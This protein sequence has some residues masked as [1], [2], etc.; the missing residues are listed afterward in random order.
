LREP[1][2]VA[3]P[4]NAGGRDRP[5]EP[6]PAQPYE[7]SRQS[8][9]CGRH[10]FL[11]DGV[12]TFDMLESGKR[13]TAAIASG[14]KRRVDLAML[15]RNLVTER[16]DSDARRPLYLGAPSPRH[17][18][19]ADGITE[20]RPRLLLR[21][22]SARCAPASAR[23]ITN[24]AARLLAALVTPPRKKPVAGRSSKGCAPRRGKTLEDS[25]QQ[26]D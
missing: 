9:S 2:R 14:G 23:H 18:L 7:R 10:V 4:A 25:D 8:N 19:K 17:R 24:E 5:R 20:S 16:S 12:G 6:I 11:R 13:C 26:K 3:Q 21:A 1:G 22:T 15:R